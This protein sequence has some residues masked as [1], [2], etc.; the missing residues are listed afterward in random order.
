MMKKSNL[1]E[2]GGEECSSI[3]SLL[4]C[5]RWNRERCSQDLLGIHICEAEAVRGKIIRDLCV[6]WLVPLYVECVL[7]PVSLEYSIWG[8]LH[9]GFIPYF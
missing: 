5:L 1:V 4:K 6:K 8:L 2:E 9:I 3:K 7:V